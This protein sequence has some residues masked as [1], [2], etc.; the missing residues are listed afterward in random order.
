VSQDDFSY[1]AAVCFKRLGG[2]HMEGLVLDVFILCSVM[3]FA[4]QL[5]QPKFPGILEPMQEI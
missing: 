4:N 3:Q 2:F 1:F 5:N